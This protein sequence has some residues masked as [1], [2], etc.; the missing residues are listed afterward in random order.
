MD[1]VN[2]IAKFLLADARA[3]LRR[4]VAHVGRTELSQSFAAW[5]VGDT[6]TDSGFTSLVNEA[7]LREGALQDFPTVAILGFGADAGILGAEQM[8]ALKKGLRRQAGREVVIDGMPVAFCADAVGVLGVALGTRAIADQELVDQVLK[9]ASKFLKKSYEAERTEDWRRCLFV[10]ADRLLGNRLNLSLPKSPAT[11]DV[12]TALVAKGVIEAGDDGS[13]DQR[14][15]HTLSLAVREL[16]DELPSDRAALRLAAIES[17]IQTAAPIVSVSTSPRSTNQGRSLSD[18]DAR[19]HSLIGTE[20]FRTCTNA[21]IQRGAKVR[22]LLH[23]EKLE[24]G[25][26][27]AKNCLDRIRAA[28]GY[29]LS[30]QIREKRSSRN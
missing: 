4:R 2:P 7:A 3:A 13:A 16:P 12:R 23:A 20:T 9:W 29:P 8:E 25:S 22:Q 26:D 18:R 27:A 21:D 14:S 19:I 17:V 6:E 15:Q 5:L 28:N 30:R 10:A 1:A 24:P 11:A